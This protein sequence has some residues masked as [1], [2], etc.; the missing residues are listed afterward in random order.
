[1]AAPTSD[2]IA[3]LAGEV[4]HAESAGEALRKV[5]D[6]RRELDA[7]ERQQ[8]ARA[9]SEGANFST[10]ARELGIS[11]QAVHRR[12]RSL[13][14]GEKPL[15]TSSDARI[16][17]RLAREEAEALAA[18]EVDGSHVVVAT[19]R[20]AELP[21]AEILR[22]AGA[23]LERAR[24]QVEASGLRGPLFKRSA[25]NRVA[26]LRPVLTASAREARERGDSQI[27]V[28]H[29]LLGTL[30]NEHVDAARTLVAIG[31][32]PRDVVAALSNA[33]RSRSR[34]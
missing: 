3:E 8:V 22:S 12:F 9:L 27:E 7:F 15:Q 2:R 21:A 33:L 11:R 25:G 31:V 23:T 18:S 30:S 28:E 29:V 17:L 26:G 20:A 5:R 6:L 1:M 13:A 19:L 4:T 34:P 16:V 14:V 10:I 32:E 24:M